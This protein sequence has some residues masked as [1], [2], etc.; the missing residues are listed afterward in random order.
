MATHDLA[1]LGADAVPIL[2]L[3]I[4]GDATNHWGVPYINLGVVDCVLVTIKFPG[5]AADTLASF[6]YDAL[7]S[8]HL[9]AVPALAALTRTDENI[10]F[11]AN[12]VASER[13]DLPFEAS[14]A[15]IRNGVQ[16]HAAVLD[17]L[18]SS[19]IA[20]EMFRYAER[21]LTK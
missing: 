11:L 6:V 2:Q 8:G 5:P 9:Y 14:A 13:S 3:L 17:V 12:A 4:S 18:Q 15:I 20:K 10:R 7:A 21:R 19:R 16:S 1:S